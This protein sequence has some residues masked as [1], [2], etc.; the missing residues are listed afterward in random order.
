[1]VEVDAGRVDT[2]IFVLVTYCVAV[3]GLVI[4]EI[5]VEPGRVFTLVSVERRVVLKVFTLVSVERRV[6]L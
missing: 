6:V 1:M 2:S 3:V 4:T 5:M